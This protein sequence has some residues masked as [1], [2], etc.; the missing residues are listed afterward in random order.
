MA[1]LLDKHLIER[2]NATVLLAVVWGGLA[3]CVLAALIYDIAAALRS[4]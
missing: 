2:A 1:Q 4:W 3:G